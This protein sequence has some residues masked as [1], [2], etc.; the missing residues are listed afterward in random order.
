MCGILFTTDPMIDRVRFLDALENMAHRGPDASSGYRREGQVSL[1]H[2]RLKILDLDD[3]SNQPFFSA[4]GRFVIIFNGEIYNYRELA[5][6][7]SI[8]LRTTGD[9]ELLIELYALMGANMLQLLNGMFAFVILD[10]K[11]QKIFAARDRLGVKPLYWYRRAGAITFA[12]EIAPILTLHGTPEMDPVGVRQYRKLRT[13]F[14]GRTIYSGI[15]M[16][17]AGHYFH[18]EKL[19]RYWDLP[20]GGKDTLADQ[21][22]RELLTTA[23]KVR[24]ISDVPVGSY[25]SGGLDSTVVAALAEKPCTWTVGFED[26]NEFEWADIAASHLRTSHRAVL[27]E[28]DEFLETATTMIRK[29][30]EP[31]SVPNEVLLYEMTKRVKEENTVV[32]SGEGAD[33][34]FFGYDRIFRWA[35]ASKWDVHRFAELYSYGSH[36]DIEIVEDAI[37]PFVNRGDAL[38]IVAAFFQVAHLH[39]LLRRLDNSTMEC[40]VE[41]RVPFVDHRLVERLAGVPFD[42]RMADNIVKAPLKRV[43]S[44]LVPPQIICRPKLG[45]PV[46]LEQLPLEGDPDDSP[47]D[48]WLNFNLRVLLGESIP[49]EE[50]KRL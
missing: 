4:D 25:L 43:F 37:G 11:L 15:E 7:Y 13:F 18:D 5:R 32:L 34:L 19:V 50:V 38:A 14:N 45:F 49:L 12:S 42:Y 29:R 27:V 3:R 17:P 16:F 20:W 24:C 1:G 23:V 39:G 40:S 36:D 26:A 2:R 9:T 30:R 22:L 44:D 48:R 6:E 31:L 33:E 21:E 28:K 47:M 8:R 35:H 41:A 10:T 46:P